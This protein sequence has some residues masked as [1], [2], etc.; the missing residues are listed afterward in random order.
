MQRRYYY[1]QGTPILCTKKVAEAPSDKVEALL[2]TAPNVPED[3]SFAPK[4]QT[5][6][7]LA[8]TGAK[9]TDDLKKKLCPQPPR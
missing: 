8:M 9:A 7:S 5:L 4:V 6:A 2:N 1:H 3:C